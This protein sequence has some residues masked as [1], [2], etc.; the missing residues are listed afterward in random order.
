MVRAVL[1]ANVVISALLKSGGPPA[2]LLDA[3]FQGG[4][5]ELVITPDILAEMERAFGYPKIRK[6]IG[7]EVGKGVI[8]DLL[9]LADLVDDRP[10]AGLSRA[11]EDDRYLAAAVEGRADYIV[12]GD[13]DLLSLREHAG[14]AIVTPREFLAVL[15]GRG[16]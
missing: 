14:V 4:A 9:L 16:A 12:T 10:M 6:R 13:D 1:D 5:F 2:K 15:D 7:D 3:Y 11:P 8:V